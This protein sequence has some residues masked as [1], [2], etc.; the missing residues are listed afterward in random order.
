MDAASPSMPTSD[1]LRERIERELAAGW[2][3]YVAVCDGSIIAMLAIKPSEAIL[4]QI[5]VLTEAQGRGVGLKLFEFAKS[6]MPDGFSLRMAAENRKA[7]RFYESG[8][9][10]VIGE[11]K[12]PV[13]RLPVKYFA[14]DGS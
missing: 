8:G 1:D 6:L 4:D 7:A 9:L 12:H 13:S 3:L 10:S 14:W 5:F 11:G 2:Q